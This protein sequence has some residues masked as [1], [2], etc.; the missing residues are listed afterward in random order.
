MNKRLRYRTQARRVVVLTGVVGCLVLLWALLGRHRAAQGPAQVVHVVAAEPAQAPP[1]AVPV[2]ASPPVSPPPPAEPIIDEITVEKRSV[3]EGEDNLITVRAHTANGTNAFLHYTIGG[4]AGSPNPVRL[5]RRKDGS[6]AWPSVRVF[7][8]NN[9]FTDAPVPRYEV[10]DCGPIRTALVS[11]SLRPNTSSEF[12]FRARVGEQ[13]TTARRPPFNGVQYRWK[14]GDGS[15]ETTNVPSVIHSYDARPQDTLNSNM[16]VEVEATSSEGEKVS[17]RTV[18]VI[19]NT[20]FEMLSVGH[21]VAL[22]TS[23][24]PRFPELDANGVVSQGIRLWH[25]SPQPVSITHV[26]STVAYADGG[27]SEPK[28]VDVAGLLGSTNVRPGADGVEFSVKLD[29][30]ADPDV[31]VVTYDVEGKSY[32]GL[33]VTGRFSVMRPPVPSGAPITDRT[34]L[35]KI[36]AAQTLLHK[37][38]VTLQEIKR[39]E[40]EGALAGLAGGADGNG[41]GIATPKSTLQAS[42]HP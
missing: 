34:M 31:R 37:D 39:L 36:G 2:R 14:F 19:R 11:Y 28:E 3:C 27:T 23:L 5:S 22:M 1:P 42:I 38:N 30:K 8:K 35:A 40:E 33:R 17:G 20:A 21:V 6:L 18:L 32:D 12:E 15:T 29:T 9:A 4:T 16:V 7:G 25:Y 24:T 10:R 13:G 26:R 41:G